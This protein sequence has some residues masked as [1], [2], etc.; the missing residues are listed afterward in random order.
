[1]MEGPGYRI[2]Y[3]KVKVGDAISG[4]ARGGG[5]GAWAPSVKSPAS[6][7]EPSPPNVVTFCTWSMKSHHFESRSAP[8]PPCRPLILKSLTTPLETMTVTQKIRAQDIQV[9]YLFKLRLKSNHYCIITLNHEKKYH[10]VASKK[11]KSTTVF[12]PPFY[13]N[14]LMSNSYSLYKQG[15]INIWSNPK[16]VCTA[17]KLGQNFK[18]PRFSNHFTHWK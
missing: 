4:V 3:D 16:N 11:V 14:L 5:T 6:R 7:L 15:R 13:F 18:G 12:Q 10:T 9:L 2:R 1:M 8:S 17:G